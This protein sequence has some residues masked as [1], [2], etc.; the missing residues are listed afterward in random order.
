MTRSLLHSLFAA[1]VLIG[2]SGRVPVATAQP[3]SE[4]EVKA[5]F[6]YNLLKFVQWPA[7]NLASQTAPFVACIVEPDPFGN[8]LN[9]ALHQKTV[10]GRPIELRRLKSNEGIRDCQVVFIPVRDTRRITAI[11]RA[12]QRAGVLTVGETTEFLD[13]GGMVS[14][15]LTDGKL[16][17]QINIEAVHASNLKMSAQLLR[18]AQD[19]KG[20]R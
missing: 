1:L 6:L 18:L 16:R 9:A 13:T 15:V 7:D 5:A 3:V 12:V 14:L 19:T 2:L 17:L 11:L 8:V 20:G 10:S 4:Y